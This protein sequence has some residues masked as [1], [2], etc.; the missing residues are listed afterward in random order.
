MCKYEDIDFDPKA[1]TEIDFQVS[2]CT[3]GLPTPSVA[4]NAQ[5]FV[6]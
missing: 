4:G 5:G 3:Y 1:S 6:I 2:K